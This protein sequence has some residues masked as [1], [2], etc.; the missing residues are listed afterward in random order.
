VSA[1][2]NAIVAECIRRRR[3]AAGDADV[4][5]QFAAAMT[6][7]VEQY[8]LAPRRTF[9]PNSNAEPTTMEHILI[10][11]RTSL[12]KPIPDGCASKIGGRRQRAAIREVNQALKRG[13]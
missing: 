6:T 1:A 11:V 9:T 8:R 5:A 10:R 2:L 13:Q 3:A 7:L 4:S 12:A